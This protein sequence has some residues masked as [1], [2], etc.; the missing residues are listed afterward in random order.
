ME[1]GRK[2]MSTTRPRRSYRCFLRHSEAELTCFD[3]RYKNC[4]RLLLPAI[5]YEG[6]RDSC[7]TSGPIMLKMEDPKKPVD[8]YLIPT[9][10]CVTARLQW[11]TSALPPDPQAISHG[12]GPA[13]GP[14]RSRKRVKSESKGANTEREGRRTPAERSAPIQ[15]RSS[16]SNSESRKRHLPETHS[17]FQSFVFN[18]HWITPVLAN[19]ENDSETPDVRFSHEAEVEPSAC[20][21]SFDTD[22]QDKS[23]GKTKKMKFFKRLQRWL[24]RRKPKEKIKS[25]A[26]TKSVVIDGPELSGRGSANSICCKSVFNEEKSNDEVDDQGPPKSPEEPAKL[27]KCNDSSEILERNG[28]PSPKITNAHVIKSWEGLNSSVSLPAVKSR[29]NILNRTRYDEKGSQSLEEVSESSERDID[30]FKIVENDAA[31]RFKRNRIVLEGG[32]AKYA[33][34]LHNDKNFDSHF[35]CL[36]D[37]KFSDI[38]NHVDKVK[39]RIMFARAMAALSNKLPKNS[40]KID[41]SELLWPTGDGINDDQIAAA[42]KSSF[43]QKFVASMNI[44]RCTNRFDVCD[45]SVMTDEPLSSTY[46][47]FITSSLLHERRNVRK[48]LRFWGK[49]KTQFRLNIGREPTLPPW[50]RAALPEPEPGGAVPGNSSPSINDITS[51]PDQHGGSFDQ[52][53]GTAQQAVGA[54]ISRIY[55]PRACSFILTKKVSCC[56]NIL[57]FEKCNTSEYAAGGHRPTRSDAAKR[58]LPLNDK[59]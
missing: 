3:Q 15:L 43:Y 8:V 31:I 41:L 1:S 5:Q 7:R 59:F 49:S 35:A 52:P 50:R 10:T 25:G 26:S 48:A 11:P 56:G 29:R 51:R 24:F 53:P 16:S 27:Q 57:W 23:E 20:N 30:R 39:K 18:S 12:A 4:F 9:E 14:I 47:D 17:A 44:M 28:I 45:R 37:A 36:E 22:Q 21:V 46:A 58:K 2:I 6:L 40:P 32:D 38:E 34:I 33:S 13:S 19:C 54:T 42:T 55:D